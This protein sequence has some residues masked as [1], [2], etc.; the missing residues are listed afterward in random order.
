MISIVTPTYNSEKYLE[1]CIQSIMQQ[2]YTEYEHIII[3]GGSTDKTLDIIK[4]YEGKYHMKWISEP[5][6]GMYDAISKGFAMAKGEILCWLNSDDRFFPWTLKIVSDV[7][8]DSKIMWVHGIPAYMTEKGIPYLNY[9]NEKCYK[10]EMIA[11]GW[12]DGQRNGCIQQESTFWKRTLYD[13]SGGLDVNYK[14]AGDFHLWRDFAKY[15]DLYTINTVLA[16]FRIH[17]G[18]KSAARSKYI[19]E[20]GEITGF[21]KLLCKLKLYKL[22]SRRIERR[23][24]NEFSL[25]VSERS[26]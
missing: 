1:E 3:D 12:Y 4:K 6:K 5:D 15:A 26:R 7:L 9:Q 25:L 16:A 22:I 8:S 20:I 21:Q 13:V 19:A 14:M 23:Y 18:Q 2:E 10:R 24:G 11:A 17:S